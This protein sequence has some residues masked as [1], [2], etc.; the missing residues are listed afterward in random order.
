M[1]ACFRPCVQCGFCDKV[2]S[3]AI[4]GVGFPVRRLHTLLETVRTQLL[5][6]NE[7][8]AARSGFRMGEAT[9]AMVIVTDGRTLSRESLAAELSRSVVSCIDRPVL[10]YPGNSSRHVRMQC[11]SQRNDL[12]TRVP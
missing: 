4:I 7:D 10:S 3:R 12:L 1:A 5:S 2:T 9:A 8:D 6:K 11:P